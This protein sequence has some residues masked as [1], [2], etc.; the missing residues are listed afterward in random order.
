MCYFVLLVFEQRH[1]LKVVSSS[2]LL[3]RAEVVN[4]LHDANMYTLTREQKYT[5]KY[6]PYHHIN[7]PTNYMLQ[8]NI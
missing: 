5:E 3:A 4:A 1:C 2:D 8:E 6:K 7:S